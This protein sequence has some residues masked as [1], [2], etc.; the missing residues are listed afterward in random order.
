MRMNDNFNNKTGWKKADKYPNGTKIK[1]LRDEGD[2]KTFILKVP[3]GYTMSSHNHNYIEQHVV[4]EGEY[5]SRGK[6]FNTGTYKYIP[7]NKQHGPY[8]SKGGAVLM[9]LWDHMK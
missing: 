3:A 2:S 1:M 4:L 6:H 9:V 8:K 5:E 7:A